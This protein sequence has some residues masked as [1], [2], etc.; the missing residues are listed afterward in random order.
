[1]STSRGARTLGQ[2]QVLTK[3]SALAYEAMPLQA[4]F[5]L[6]IVLIVVGRVDQGY[7]KPESIFIKTS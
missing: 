6:K 7:C 4:Y 1:M 2:S 3:L 5:R